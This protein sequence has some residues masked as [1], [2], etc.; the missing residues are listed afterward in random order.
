[1]LEKMTVPR[2]SLDFGDYVDM[3]RRNILWVI[4]PAFLCLVVTTVVVYNLPD[5]YVSTALIRVE[6]QSVPEEYIRNAVNQSLADRINAMAQSIESR[7]TMGTIISSYGLYKAELKREPLDDVIAAMQRAIG[8]NVIGSITNTGHATPAFLLSFSYSDRHLAQRVCQELVTRFINASVRERSEQAIGTQQ[9]LDDEFEKA[10]RELGVLEQEVTAF[11][12]KNAGHLPEQMEA[13]VQQLNALQQRMQFLNQAQ[14]RASQERMMLE[15]SLSIAQDRLAAV[16]DVSPELLARN[17]RLD[18]LDKQITSAESSISAMRERVT[19]A[20]PDLEAARAQLAQLKE[21]REQLVTSEK[22]KAPEVKAPGPNREKLDAQ[23]QVEQIRTLI[24]AK[25]IETQELV[26]ETV[27]ATAAMKGYQARIEE[28]PLGEREFQDLIRDRELAKN[29]Y[30]ELEVKRSKAQM[31]AEM[32]QRKQSETLEAIDNASLPEK[33]TE[34]KRQ[35]ILPAGFAVGIALGLLLVGVREIKDTSL[36]NLK[37]ARLYTQLPILG[38]V[39]L[40]E[41]DLVVQRRKQ[42]TWLGW[43]AATLGGIAVIAGTIAHYYMSRI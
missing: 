18:S 37:D 32:E 3:L 40:L 39:P 19:D 15:S 5:T 28:V 21:Q 26:K 41:N 34:P 33:P 27:A 24:K 12:V 4:G 2:R 7:T 31:A 23:A 8:I 11:R 30:N 17:E 29:R 42:M 1:M 13:N 22:A 43:A 35:V 14:S 38:S 25:D 20:H 36:R 10:K 9:L 6:P 16:K